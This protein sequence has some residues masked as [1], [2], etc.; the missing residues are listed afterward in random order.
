MPQKQFPRGYRGREL[1]PSSE[2]KANEQPAPDRPMTLGLDLAPAKSV[3]SARDHGVAVIEVHPNGPAAQ[4]GLQTGDVILD[5]DQ[6]VVNEPADVRK[7]VEAAHA[8]STR[9]VLMRIKRGA[10]MQFVAITLG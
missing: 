2:A 3:A 10:A 7:D 9:A 5:V 1:P 6:N 8:R 4:S